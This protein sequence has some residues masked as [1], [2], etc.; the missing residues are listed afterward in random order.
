MK[1]IVL[2]AL[3][4][5]ALPA[6]A[7]TGPSRALLALHTQ[8]GTMGSIG[9]NVGVGAEWSLHDHLSVTL[10]LGTSLDSKNG[11]APSFPLD[12]SAGARVY[13][14]QTWLY[15]EL[16]YGFLDLRT[17][18]DEPSGAYG[19]LQKEYG[20]SYAVGVRTPAWHGVYAGASVGRALGDEDRIL[21]DE[22]VLPRFGLT[23][24]VELGR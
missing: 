21:F 4:L 14:F 7:Q 16:A 24:G 11:T 23:V 22:G 3:A 10:S 1:T 6:A 15:G 20:L 8:L 18:R 2:C 12:A 19:P 13:P 17:S 5:L 9:G